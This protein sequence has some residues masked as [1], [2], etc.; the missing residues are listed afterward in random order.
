MQIFIRSILSF[1]IELLIF[2]AIWMSLGI[3][4]MDI[5]SS[6]FINIYGLGNRKLNFFLHGIC[7]YIGGKI[8]YYLIKRIVKALQSNNN[9]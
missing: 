5:N 8:I 2:C 3:Y 4:V 7:I 6:F 1:A 9:S